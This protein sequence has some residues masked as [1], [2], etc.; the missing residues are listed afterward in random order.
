MPASPD[1]SSVRFAAFFTVAEHSLKVGYAVENPTEFTLALLNRVPMT[2]HDMSVRIPVEGAFIEL[3]G[4]QLIIRKN[5]LTLPEGMQAAANP[6]PFM[7]EVAPGGRFAEQ[8]ELATPVRVNHPFVEA[9]I[10]RGH[11]FED[12]RPVIPAQATKVTFELGAFAV[13]GST[14][15]AS[16][17]AQYPGVF[18]LAGAMPP[19]R[20]F[21]HNEKL[22][23]PISVL[24]FGLVKRPA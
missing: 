22:K 9:L 1:L 15:L 12:A 16:L 13:Y 20:T 19:I 7:M 4:E 5:L 2:E 21:V 23:A 14:K 11:P 10:A 17:G 6:V 8:F 18:R 24:Q 3:S